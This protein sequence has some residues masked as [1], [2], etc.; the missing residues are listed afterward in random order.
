MI[1]SGEPPRY[2]IDLGYINIKLGKN[3]GDGFPF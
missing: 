1:N 2:Q 3:Y